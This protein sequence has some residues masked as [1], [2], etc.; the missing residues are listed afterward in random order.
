MTATARRGWAI[1]DGIGPFFRDLRQ[2]RI[3]WSK[4]HF[5]RLATE[6]P[7]RETQWARIR[8]DVERFVR[9]VRAL[10]YDT[11][12]F[13]DLA[14]LTDDPWYEADVRARIAVWSDEFRRV[15]AIARA[16]GM[17][18]LVTADFVVTTPAVEARLGRGTSARI[19]WFGGLVERFL[20]AFPE[21]DGLVLRI[22]ES[23]GHDVA[24]I[25]RSALSVRTVRDVR[26]LLKRI[27]PAFER[28][29]RILIFRTWTVGA[30]LIGDL[31]WHRARL[32]AVF[33]GICSDALVVSMKYG[34][35]DFFRYLPL[36]RQFFRIRIATIVEFQARREYEG[37][38]EYP[39]FVGW[40]CERH[41]RAL[42]EAPN[43]VGF[44]VWCQT[45]GWH[46]FRRRAFLDPEAVWIELNAAVVARMILERVSVEDAVKG[47]VGE[48]RA[49]VCL[50]L[51]RRSD[52]VVREI[53]YVEE[54]AR[55]KLFFRR[56]RIPPLVHVFWDCIFVNDATRR[57]MGHF[58]RDPESAIRAGEAAFG[59]FD[60]ME[61]LAAKAGWPV[62]DI[63]FMRDTFALVLLARRFYFLA[64]DPA[65]RDEILA[66]KTA[67]KQRWPRDVR[68]RYRIRTSFEPLRL[69]GRTVRWVLGLVVRRRRGYRTVL[70]HLF[71]MRVLA[72]IY[73]LFRARHQKALP[74]MVRK[75]AMGVDALFR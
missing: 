26:A 70:D 37:A 32:A 74:K 51:L 66:A 67:Y 57:V 10:G 33:D 75:T 59:H 30:Y 53:L 21:V 13:D 27:L 64:D 34:E 42:R 15:F 25:Q 12:T 1:I 43:L 39:S 28:R 63:R 40:E 68:Q 47:F 8:D 61:E 24:D 6:G 29:S 38:G 5:M 62:E 16:H 49:D 72:W 65:L 35:S 2:R 69:R 20:D 17:R 56:V 23:D 71:T 54:F 11:V 18:V 41:L 60:A 31:I 52:I 22:G 46:A 50:E 44:S 73:R 36:N 55:Q 58:V 48:E 7:E 19:E 45:G 4:I 9:R 14:H 3:N